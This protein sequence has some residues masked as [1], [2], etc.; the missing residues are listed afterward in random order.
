MRPPLNR[1]RE[2]G[3]VVWLIW[4]FIGFTIVLWGVFLT[5]VM[6]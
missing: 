1:K 2:C 6:I 5:N 3:G 4:M